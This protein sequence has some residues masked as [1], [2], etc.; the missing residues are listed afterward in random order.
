MGTLI[1]FGYSLFLLGVVVM[2]ANSHSEPNYDLMTWEEHDAI[3]A[4]LIDGKSA[5]ELLH[6][7]GI[8]EVLSEEWNNDILDIWADRRAEVDDDGSD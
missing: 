4:E 7:P 8:Y 3:L 2:V 5:K 1:Q 6:I